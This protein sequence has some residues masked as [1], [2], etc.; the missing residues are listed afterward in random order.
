MSRTFST[1]LEKRTRTILDMV[2]QGQ[3]GAVIIHADP[4]HTKSPTG[5]RISVGFPVLVVTGWVAEA[6]RFAARVA[7]LLAMDEAGL[8]PSNAEDSAV[9]GRRRDDGCVAEGEPPQTTVQP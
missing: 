6:A 7:E 4:V 8:I 5:E 3:E 9:A 2:D 1:T